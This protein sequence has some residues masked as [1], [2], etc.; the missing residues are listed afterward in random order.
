MQKFY[1][2]KSSN[3]S[4]L[5]LAVSSLSCAVQ[6]RKI[7]NG[8]LVCWSEQYTFSKASRSLMSTILTGE[9]FVCTFSGPGVTYLQTR[10]M[11]GLAGALVPY[12]KQQSEGRWGCEQPVVLLVFIAFLSL[13]SV[14][15]NRLLD[16]SPS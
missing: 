4:V 12:L 7:D 6:V 16:H 11:N 10:S 14:V 13:A 2:K 1:K 3:V 5:F 15:V 9:C 8:F